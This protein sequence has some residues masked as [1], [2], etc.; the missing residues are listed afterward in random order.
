DDDGGVDTA[1]TTSRTVRGT[2]LSPLRI[3]G[4][5][6]RVEAGQVLPV[7]IRLEACSGSTELQPSIR[8]RRGDGVTRGGEMTGEELTLPTV[9]TSQT[10]GVMRPTGNHFQYDLLV[11]LAPG[12]WTI[13]VYP[14]GTSGS[15]IR[16]LI[17]VR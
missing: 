11:D 9:S 16:H 4:S 15:S 6:R 12:T 5:A 8:V 14:N 17:E 2:W 1:S 10:H 3:D 13:L 7:K